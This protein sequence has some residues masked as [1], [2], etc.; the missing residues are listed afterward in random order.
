[1]KDFFVA[2]LGLIFIVGVTALSI[3]AYALPIAAAILIALWIID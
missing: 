2:L 3:L 1:M